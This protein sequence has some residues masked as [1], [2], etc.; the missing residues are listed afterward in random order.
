[1]T[2]L[3]TLFVMRIDCITNEESNLYLRTGGQPDE[4]SEA[5]LCPSGCS[6]LRSD[7][8]FNLPTRN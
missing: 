5:R 2:P 1:M 8:P 3:S 6:Q 7:P 4:S